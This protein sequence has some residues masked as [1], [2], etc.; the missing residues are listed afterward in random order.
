MGGPPVQVGPRG[1]VSRGS[2]CYLSSG[3]PM[4][5]SR[6]LTR[7]HGHIHKQPLARLCLACRGPLESHGDNAKFC[8]LHGSGRTGHI[9]NPLGHGST[10]TIRPTP[11]DCFRCSLIIMHPVLQILGIFTRVGIWGPG[12]SVPTGRYMEPWARWTGKGTWTDEGTA[13]RPRGRGGKYC[14]KVT[15]ESGVG[16]SRHS[17]EPALSQDGLAWSLRPPAILHISHAQKEESGPTLSSPPA[18]PSPAGPFLKQKHLH[19]TVVVDQ[20]NPPA[21][22]P[23][24]PIYLVHACSA[25]R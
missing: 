24:L 7:W 16:S 19:M 6:Q 20:I 25:R 2:L 14:S 23:S 17:L 15:P 4:L 22:P 12:F 5:V 13:G 9:R 1:L 10:V 18:S 11:T 3:P 8:V 21:R